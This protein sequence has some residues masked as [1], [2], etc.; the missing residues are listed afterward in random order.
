MR[1]RQHQDTTPMMQ[2]EDLHHRSGRT[3]EEEKN[4]LVSPLSIEKEQTDA[5]D[6]LPVVDGNMTRRLVA[7]FVICFTLLLIVGNNM[8]PSAPSTGEYSHMKS[9]MILCPALEVSFVW[10]R[11]VDRQPYS[12][13]TT[14]KPLRNSL[15][16]SIHW[17]H[18]PL[19][20]D[21]N[22]QFTV[23]ILQIRVWIE[24]IGSVIY[25][26][27]VAFSSLNG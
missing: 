5:S 22:R 4:P 13:C 7:V 27:F 15:K 9:S 14:P 8:S 18:T 25:C 11:T 1:R 26:V 2:A 17:M 12:F 3:D 21:C 10:R 6:G 19:A 20:L 23:S 16:A 24:G